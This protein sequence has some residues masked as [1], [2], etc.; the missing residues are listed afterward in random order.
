MSKL[1]DK[2]K[3]LAEKAY[4]DN[5]SVPKILY[6]EIKKVDTKHNLL[7]V[8]AIDSFNKLSRFTNVRFPVANPGITLPPPR[9]GQKVLMLVH[10]NDNK[11][12]IIISSQY[13]F[14]YTSDVIDTNEVKL[15]RKTPRARGV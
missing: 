6:G 8:E 2:I 5:P 9:L 11:S 7:D 1:S 3:V 15:Q 13:R 4:N 14:D 10:G 12:P